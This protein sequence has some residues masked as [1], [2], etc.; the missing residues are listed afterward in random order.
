M[1]AQDL[2]LDARRLGIQLIA[3]GSRLRYRAPRG[4][5]TAELRVQLEA[6]L[7]EA[8]GVLRPSTG[9]SSG[10]ATSARDE[11]P[12]A[13]PLGPSVPRADSAGVSRGLVSELV[14]SLPWQEE[15]AGWP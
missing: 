5:M 1:T 14:H 3:E 13:E 9:T 11:P 4:V 8:L 12:L 6:N 15:I 2:I 10:N 7:V